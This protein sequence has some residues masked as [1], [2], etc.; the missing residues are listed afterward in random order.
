LVVVLDQEGCTLPW[1]F[2]AQASLAAGAD[3][4]QIRQ[5]GKPARVLAE[6]TSQ[7]VDLGIDTSAITVNGHP[8]VA[9][10]LG[11]NLH[12]PESMV[13]A[14]VHI[15]ANRLLSRSIHGPVI[16]ESSADYLVLGNVQETESHPG[17]PGLGAEMVRSIV[18][19]CS[20]PILAIGGVRP[21]NID[22]I[23]ETGVHGVA[24]RSFIIAS[25]DPEAATR[26]M[27]RKLESWYR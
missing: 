22:S 12:L 14:T 25:E 7:L 6:M 21:D 23:L 9:E 17:K 13:R 26:S 16:E 8:E 1:Q 20:A 11:T 27:R 3:Q 5:P 19:Q 10:A 24:V 18:S 4:I 15:D 2:V